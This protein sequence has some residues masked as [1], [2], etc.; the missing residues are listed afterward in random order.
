MSVRSFSHRYLKIGGHDWGPTVQE[1][2]VDPLDGGRE[3]SYR[4]IRKCRLCRCIEKDWRI[5]DADAA[6]TRQS[7]ARR[8]P[9]NKA[10]NAMGDWRFSLVGLLLKPL[11]IVVLLILLL[12]N[13]VSL[14]AR[15]VRG[16]FGIA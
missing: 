9:P 13:A 15:G 10:S 11:A 16:L 4:A 14:S 5:V 1:S 2:I 8:T 7:P 6:Q 3:I 12:A